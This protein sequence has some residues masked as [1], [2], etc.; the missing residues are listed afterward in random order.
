MEYTTTL[1]TPICYSVWTKFGEQ[2]ITA[3]IECYNIRCERY[4]ML[5]DIYNVCGK[6]IEDMRGDICHN[7]DIAIKSLNYVSGNK[8]IINFKN[9]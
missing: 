6:W 8:P 9:K 3:V 2:M 5:V 7:K 4:Y 1:G